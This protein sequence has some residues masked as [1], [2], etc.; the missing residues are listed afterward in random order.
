MLQIFFMTANFVY[1]FSAVQR[2]SAKAE[3]R[4]VG[5]LR[6]FFFGLVVEWEIAFTCL[7]TCADVFASVAGT[8]HN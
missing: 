7:G 1:S 6:T 5:V 2:G 3:L 8:L 4:N